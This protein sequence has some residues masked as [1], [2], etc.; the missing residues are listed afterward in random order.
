MTDVMNI[1]DLQD[2]QD[3]HNRALGHVQAIHAHYLGLGYSLLQIK[4]KRLFEQL[5]FDSFVDYCA[6]PPESGGLGLQERS[7]QI[8]MQMAERYVVTLGVEIERLKEI[9]KSNLATL[10]PVVTKDNMDL[11]L[12]DAQ[13]YSNRDLRKLK[14]SGRY[15]GTD[16]ADLNAEDEPEPITDD[17]RTQ[18]PHC[19]RWF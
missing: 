17:R 7:R 13:A 14:A 16:D 2:A 9:P 10:L 11:V 3:E 6:A 12:S 4:E 1:A 18:C 19:G 8:C 5:G 15:S